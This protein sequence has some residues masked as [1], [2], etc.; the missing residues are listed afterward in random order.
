LDGNNGLKRNN[1]K[2]RVIYLTS[3]ESGI[4][5]HETAV[6][7]TVKGRERRFPHVL[8]TNFFLR[9]SIFKLNKNV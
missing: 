5:P 4:F 8:G 3:A 7:Q 2:L 6:A 1:S 9:V